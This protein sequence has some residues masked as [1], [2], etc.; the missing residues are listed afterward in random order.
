[1]STSSP[2]TSRV[3]TSSESPPAEVRAKP[4]RAHAVAPVSFPSLLPS[5]PSF[6]PWRGT[7]TPSPSTARDPIDTEANL[8]GGRHRRGAR[9]ARRGSPCR[10]T[11]EAL[12][13]ARCGSSELSFSFTL[14]PQLL[15][16]AHPGEV[17]TLLPSS[18]ARDP[19]DTEANLRGGRH[20][21]GA[22]CARRGACRSSAP[23]RR[24]WTPAG[25]TCAPPR[26]HC[27]R[28]ACAA[29]AHGRGYRTRAGLSRG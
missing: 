22:R 18:T 28:R 20:R 7:D 5:F 29:K 6:S 4:C 24:V 26:R 14:L 2:R 21:R 13:C 11:R 16:R 8:R 19:I 27:D 12:S 23:A 9:G 15:R 10:G 25:C 3:E 17:L 1:M